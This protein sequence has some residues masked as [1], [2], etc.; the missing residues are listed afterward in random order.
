MITRISNFIYK[1]DNFK[2][3][4]LFYL[5]VGCIEIILRY[6]Y[7]P[8]PL[9]LLLPAIVLS[10]HLIYHTHR[11][12]FKQRS[13]LILPFISFTLFYLF[14]FLKNDYLDALYYWIPI[15]N[16]SCSLIALSFAV[17]MLFRFIKY[18]STLFSTWKSVVLSILFMLTV[19]F[20]SVNLIMTHYYL[21]VLIE[22]KNSITILSTSFWVEWFLLLT[23]LLTIAI[24]LLFSRSEEERIVPTMEELESYKKEIVRAFNEEKMFLN[25]NF[26]LKV[27]A[28]ES[29]I[30][31]E[32]LSYFFNYYA[33]KSFTQLTAEYRI[34]YALDLMQNQGSNYT[35]EAIAHACGYRSRA[36]FNKYFQFVTGM[37]PS[38]YIASINK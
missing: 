5:L 20:A 27:L 18:Q 33:Y 13:F 25:P 21:P 23:S 6:F 14:L 26:S 12:S 30:E 15:F 7:M 24:Y 38:E 32:N 19:I 28:I 10:M 35:L 37:L 22:D 2:K 31:Q 17:P 4:A 11:I 3:L 36:S 34:G 8:T 16:I 1:G 29:G 9:S